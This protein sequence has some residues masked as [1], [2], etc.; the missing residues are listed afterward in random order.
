MHAH[1]YKLSLISAL[2]TKTYIL[3]VLQSYFRP[4]LSLQLHELVFF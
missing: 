2:D 4:Q 1:L 3:T